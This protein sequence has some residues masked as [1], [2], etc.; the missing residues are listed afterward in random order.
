MLDL[1]SI[2]REA[3]QKP[4]FGAASGKF[5]ALDTQTKSVPLQGETGSSGVSLLALR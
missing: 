1:I 5:V 4:V 3:S 2:L